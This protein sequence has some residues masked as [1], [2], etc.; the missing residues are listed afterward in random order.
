MY[1]GGNARAHPI[2]YT[3]L[4]LAFVLHSL[5]EVLTFVT[6]E[7]VISSLK[8]ETLKSEITLCV[9]VYPLSYLCS[10]SSAF[11]SIFCNGTLQFDS[12]PYCVD[13]I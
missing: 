12:N 4:F 11:T 8:S 13:R 7:R 5:R 3:M 10:M 6:A 9:Y 2:P 1:M